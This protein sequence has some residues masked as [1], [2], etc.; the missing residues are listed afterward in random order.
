MK[1]DRGTAEVL[2]MARA[3]D[4]RRDEEASVVGSYAWARKELQRTQQ[5]LHDTHEKLRKS[6]KEVARLQEDNDRQNQQLLEMVAEARRLQGELSD[7]DKEAERL[8]VL[9]AK[10]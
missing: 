4:E 1:D 6:K 8:R 3:A 5:E 7:A 2:G 10:R 9:L